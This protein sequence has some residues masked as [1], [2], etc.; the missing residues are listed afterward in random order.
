MQVNISGHQLDVTDSMRDYVGE[1]LG[2]LERHFDRI[3]NVQV[4]MQVEKL[5]Q[6]I[7]ATLHVA[8]REV[9]ANAEHEDMYAAIDLLA[10]K[11]DRQLIKHK[12]KQLDRLQGAT[13]R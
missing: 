6:K 3:T 2:R 9:V 10:D 1:K 8:G 5:K 13:A 7:E 4:I 12:E 11:L